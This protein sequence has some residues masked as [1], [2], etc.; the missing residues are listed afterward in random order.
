MYGGR[1][2]EG[3]GGSGTL[4]EI[5]QIRGGEVVDGLECKQEDCELY[6]ELNRDPVELLQDRSDVVDRGGAS[7]NMGS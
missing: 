6:T 2:S 3:A 4:E 5:R 7:Y 1:G